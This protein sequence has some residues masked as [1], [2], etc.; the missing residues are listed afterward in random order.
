MPRRSLIWPLALIGAFAT[1]VTLLMLGALPAPTAAQ[2]DDCAEIY[3]TP[4]PDRTS[5]Q[6]TATALAPT[7]Y[8]APTATS[9]GGGGGQPAPA[10]TATIS[11]TATLTATS[12]LSPTSTEGPT[13]T[14]TATREP[15]GSPTPTAT[16]T[17][18]GLETIVC[19]PGA[20][21]AIRGEA[22]PGAPL[23]AYFNERPVGGALT[24][25]DGTYLILLTVG[26]ERPG[27]YPVTVRE[28][29][30]RA[31]VRELACEVPGATPTPTRELAG[32]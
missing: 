28:R 21:V 29:D 23:L 24:R 12:T 31:L 30:G 3:P 18:V 5:C 7:A 20:T 27:V 11:A 16:S 13:S 19:A 32:G 15:Q 8:P 10:P 25:P 1:L 2:A 26:A 6:Q 22:E 4:G 17:L 14:P 9:G